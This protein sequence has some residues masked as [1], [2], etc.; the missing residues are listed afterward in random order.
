MKVIFLKDAP[1]QGKKGEIKDVS[2]GYAQNFL[3]PKGFVQPATV[4]LQAKIAKEKRE[5]EIKRAKEVKKLE[6]LKADMEKRVFTVKVKVGE[7]GQIYGSVHEKEIATA[8]ASKLNH[9]LEK[10]QIEIARPIRG[11]GEHR[12]KVKLGHGIIAGAK[13]HVEAM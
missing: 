3:I 7:K 5:A 11:V 10:G 1:G 6:E 12:V 2:P 8:I 13:I 9:P 4:E